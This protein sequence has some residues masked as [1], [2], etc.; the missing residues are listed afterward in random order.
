MVEGAQGSSNVECEF[1]DPPPSLQI[2]QSQRI[3]EHNAAHI[4]RDSKVSA[5]DEPCGLCLRPSPLC[6]FYL[7]KGKGRNASLTVD[8]KRSECKYEI[9]FYY[10]TASTSSTASPCSNA[11]IHCPICGTKTPAVWKYNMKHHF[12]RKHPTHLKKPEF[13]KLWEIDAAEDYELGE[14]WKKRNS[15]PT[16]RRKSNKQRELVVSDAHRSSNWAM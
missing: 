2:S 9:N 4:L 7:K 13:S 1:C 12:K 6:K 14:I 8:K 5:V 16:V 15:G 10:H 3:L 11:P